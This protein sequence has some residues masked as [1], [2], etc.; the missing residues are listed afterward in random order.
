MADPIH[1]FQI[2]KLFTIAK[3]GPAEIAFTNSALYMILAVTVVC[4]C[5]IGSGGARA[6]VAGRVES[7]WERVYELVAEMIRGATGPEGMQFFPLVFSLFAF[8]LV[9]N[10]LGLIPF[11]FTVTSHLII[12]AALALLVFLTVIIAGFWK[13]GVHFLKIFVPSGIPMYI[14]PLITVMEVFSFFVRPVSHSV[15]LFANMLAGHITLKVFAGFVI[16]LG[17]AGVL[18]VLLSRPPLAP[19]TALP[20]RGVLVPV[21]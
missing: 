15:R 1:Q 12:T 7:V 18:G 3:I 5:L 19:P 8:I 17:A 14:L 2:N 13:H 16:M 11:A 6:V 20:P 21:L 10:V 4:A 9:A